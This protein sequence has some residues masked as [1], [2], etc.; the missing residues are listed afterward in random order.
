[1]RRPTRTSSR[2][3]VRRPGGPIAS[4][5]L[6]R[7]LFQRT[8]CRRHGADSR[9]IDDGRGRWCAR[10]PDRRVPVAPVADRSDCPLGA[11]L[12]DAERV[13]AEDTQ[14]TALAVAALVAATTD[15]RLLHA[16]KVKK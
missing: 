13:E 1:P 5:S 4:C 12:Q 6:T 3:A 9:R 15:G 16:L 11:L 14:V 2:S 7:F 8:M 10:D